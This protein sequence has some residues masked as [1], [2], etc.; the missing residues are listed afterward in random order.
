MKEGY[1]HDRVR[2]ELKE[3]DFYTLIAILLYTGAFTLIFC[4]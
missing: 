2:R 4:I 1:S 3:S